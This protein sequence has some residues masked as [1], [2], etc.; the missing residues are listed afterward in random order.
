[1]NT[2]LLEDYESMEWSDYCN[3]QLQDR[4]EQ[5]LGQKALEQYEMWK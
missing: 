4:M 2:V 3:M 5:K 1:M